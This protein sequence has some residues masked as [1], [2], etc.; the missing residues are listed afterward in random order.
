M[1]PTEEHRVLFEKYRPLEGLWREYFEFRGVP[2]RAG[3]RIIALPDDLG[4]K[5]FRSRPKIAVAVLLAYGAREHEV[6]DRH[7]AEVRTLR[8]GMSLSRSSGLSAKRGVS[9]CILAMGPGEM[10]IAVFSPGLG[11]K[12]NSLVGMRALE[13]P[14]K[15]LGPSSWRHPVENL[16]HRQLYRSRPIDDRRGLSPGRVPLNRKRLS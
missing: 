12:G 7:H 13:V 8:G 1:K 14:S 4:V 15:D 3:Q 10:S 2:R 9:G 16:A 11:S 5:K 6:A